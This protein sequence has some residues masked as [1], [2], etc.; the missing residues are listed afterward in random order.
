GESISTARIPEPV[1]A[2]ADAK[3]ETT[4]EFLKKMIT[5]IRSVRNVLG[6][7][8]ST[9]ASVKINAA[10]EETS[11]IISENSSLIDKLARTEVS[12]GVGIEKPKASAGAVV[13]GT[14]VFIL[15]EG[16][17]DLEKEKERLVKEIANV[18][19]YVKQVEG[20]LSNES[21]A[22]RAPQDVVEGERQKL[23]AGKLNL[24]KLRENL[25]SLS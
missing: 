13:E 14:E 15:L 22:L 18:E 20:K 24:Q 1:D 10:S 21:F 9:I 17:I 8:P 2:W 5:E 23:E 19:K 16:L 6:V 11:N 12:V 25:Q 7:P 3:A 4:M